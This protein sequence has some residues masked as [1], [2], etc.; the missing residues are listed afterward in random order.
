VACCAAQYEL[1]EAKAK[2]CVGR[3]YVPTEDR[4]AE[5]GQVKFHRM[6]TEK[7]IANRE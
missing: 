5:K 4:R 3:S 2:W 1:L 6:I 7:W